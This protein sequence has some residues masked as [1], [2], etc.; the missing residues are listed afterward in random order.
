[1]MNLMWVHIYV[2]VEIPQALRLCVPRMNSICISTSYLLKER[3]CSLPLDEMG[4]FSVLWGRCLNA[5][6][7]ATRN[8][9]CFQ[10][11]AGLSRL[12]SFFLTNR[13]DES[14][15]YYVFLSCKTTAVTVMMCCSHQHTYKVNGMGGSFLTVTFT[16]VTSSFLLYFQ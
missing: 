16:S 12:V 14:F 5:V 8:L 4:L 1:M 15:W 3:P 6:W 10:S 11:R 13:A 9:P 2:S 7:A